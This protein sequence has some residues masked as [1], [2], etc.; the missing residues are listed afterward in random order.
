ADPDAVVP[1]SL[2][3]ERIWFLDQLDPGNRAYHAQ[4]TIRLRGPLDPTVLRAALDEIV[5]RHD[6]FRTGF[7]AGPHGPEQRI[8]AHRAVDLPLV[9]VS[10]LAEPER[11]RR[12]EETVTGYLREPFDLAEPPLARWAL[13]RHA[14][15]DHTLVHVE[16]HLVHDGWSFA[17]FVD[18]LT[19]LYGSYAAGR[20]PDLP[21][22]ACRY[23]DF[24]LW[25]RHWMQGEALDRHLAHWTRELAGAP[26]ELALPLD[27]PRPLTQSFTGAALRVELPGE[28]CRRLRAY[29]RRHGVTLY[30]T[31]LA[32][33]ATL[34][35]RYARQDDMII[36]SGVANRRL[37]ETERLIGMVVN[38]LPLRVDLSGRPGFTELVRRV[39]TRAATAYEWA[40]VPLDRLVDAL[41]PVR[42]P[43]RNPL[44]QT[45]FSFHDSPM[46]QLAFAGLTGSVLERHNGTAKT[47]LNIVVLPR[48]EQHAG[49]GHR[50]DA[51]P[52]T[53]I[54]EYATALFD[55]QTMRRMTAHYTRLLAAA[56]TD[57]D[58]PV[59]RLPLLGAEERARIVGTYNRTTVPFPADRTVPEL[60]AEQVARHPHAPAVEYD[61]RTLSYAD[62]DVQAEALARLLRERG[63]GCDT[64]VG[65]L[66]ERGSELVTAFLAVLKAG[67][68]YVPLDPGYPGERLRWLL[69]DSGARLVVT[70]ADLAGLL[71]ADGVAVVTADDPPTGD[72]NGSVAVPAPAAPEPAPAARPDSAAYVL[73][74]SGSTGRPKGVVVAHRA[75]LRLVCG[76]DFVRF[77]PQERIAQVADA[78][79]DAIT[80]EVWGALLHGGTVCVIPRDTVLSPGALGEQLRRS[81]VTS[82]FLTSAL[83][84]EVMAH[85]PDSFAT[86]T[87]LL[88]GGDALNPVRIRQL[89]RGPHAPARLLN[90]YGPTETTTFAVVHHITDLPDGATSVPIGRPIANTTA[91]VL[92]DELHPVPEGVP[93]QLYLGGPG[94][95]RGYAGRPALTAQRFVPD[96]FAADGS[97]LYHTGDVVRWRSDGV[98]EFLGRSDDQVK[99]SGFRIEPGEVEN[100]LL[101]HPAVAGAAVVVD[102]APTG[103]RL[104]GYVVPATGQPAPTGTQLRAWLTERLPPYLVP[105]AYVSL[106]ALPLTEH[107][108]LD[109]AALPAAEAERPDLTVAYR[110][111]RSD[112][113]RAVA[114]ICADL[115]GLDQVGLDDDFFAL[116]GHS[117]LAMRLVARVNETFGAEV[118]LARFLRTPT[119]ACLVTALD[120]GTPAGGSPGEPAASGGIAA[121]GWQQ[122]EH[123]LQHIDQLTPEQVDQLLHD[124]ADNEAER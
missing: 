107:G 75:I 4:A 48:A 52:I 57:P 105:A 80:F 1:L 71:P 91:Y 56:L 93:G 37:A 95:A 20:E 61:G 114:A 43:A 2:P 110:A 27:R 98:L 65:V 58:Q 30:A 54:W 74:T 35:G 82:M 84:N 34:L 113:E 7:V 10:M 118:P 88:V 45:M 77:G 119:V 51:A 123:L 18:E 13:I 53:L 38:T 94:V 3:Q 121:G 55:E 68:A 108:K 11:S 31:M 90:G 50:D 42:D 16:H 104:V 12:A 85:R 111:P 100:T 67:G 49:H 60:F 25:Q 15:N 28:L 117:L 92:D 24:T 66:F 44:F 97:R 99:I 96:P 39:H 78:S 115:I 47:D 112:T 81:A 41:E 103:R 59:G 62:L 63:V 6:I 17:V 9:D 72:G 83:F 89:L 109:R 21:P 86:M 19:R 29:S 73:Y 33:F 102:D 69:A 46:P 101:D 79:F 116:G 40:D 32:G 36:G 122:M 76:T 106:A 87:N 64:P 14:D 120:S 22:P 23:R 5:R 70:R 26:H 8:A 124:F